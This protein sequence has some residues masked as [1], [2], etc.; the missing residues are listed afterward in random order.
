V[1]FDSFV[2]GFERLRR[3]QPSAEPDDLLVV[4]AVDST[5][6]LARALAEG[7]ER[8][9]EAF[10]S[11]LLLALEQTGGRGRRGRSWSSPRGRGVYATRVVQ[12]DEPARM[13]RLPLL[14][15]IG[16]CAGIAAVADAAVRLKWPNDLVVEVGGKRRKLGGVLIESWTGSEGR[17]A[18]C[19]GFGVNL[20]HGP[21]E[22]PEQ[23]ISLHAL[24]HTAVDLPALAWSL[25]RGL[26]AELRWLEGGEGTEGDSEGAGVLARYRALSVHRLGEPMVCQVGEVAVAG[27][28]QGF[29]AAGRLRLAT[30][31]GERVLSAGEVIER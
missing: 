15:G 3:L 4:P 24:G 5:N 26:E 13:Q 12:V 29:D 20:S 28:F 2:S 17:A 11:L 31:M 23:G 9:A 14:V 22:L 6:R 8:E 10:P 30:E 1:N 21:D 27:T 19:I 25:S 16:L 18:A 7:F